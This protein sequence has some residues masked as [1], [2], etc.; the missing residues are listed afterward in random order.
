MENFN[1]TVTQLLEIAD[2]LH[3][4]IKTGLKKD[5]TEIKALPTFVHPKKD[6]IRGE[7][8]VLDLGG[9]NF[10]AATI[11]VGQN[12]QVNDIAERNITEMKTPHF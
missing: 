10:R 7:A 4:K 3:E 2:N 12:T 6:E 1:L 5:G 9:T 11:S 8:V